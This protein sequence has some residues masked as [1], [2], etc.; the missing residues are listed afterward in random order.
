[1]LQ[2]D[3]GQMKNIKGRIPVIWI[4]GSL[5]AAAFILMGV[6]VLRGRTVWFDQ[7]L[8]DVIQGQES[9]GLTRIMETFTFIGN[10]WPV[11]VITL[12]IMTYLYLILGHRRELLLLSCVMLGS[13]VLNR[14][15]KLLYARERPTFH[16]LIEETG[17]SFPSGH[18]MSAFCLYSTVAYLLWR[19]IQDRKGRVLL[20]LI[21]VMFISVIGLSRIYLGVH[22]PSDVI[23]AYLAGGAWV[24][25]CVW[26][27]KRY[28]I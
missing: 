26:L 20:V 18:S 10:G 12:L 7:I 28:L 4:I 27:Y 22:Y 19:H 6:F 3:S 25:C 24:S 21:S 14:L 17:Y 15:L 9:P 13:P 8:I 1:M 23:G 5:C 11:I 2:H 16:R